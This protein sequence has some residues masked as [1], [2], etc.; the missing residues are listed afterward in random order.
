MEE[1][2]QTNPETSKIWFLDFIRGRIG[3]EFMMEEVTTLS[4]LCWLCDDPSLLENKRKYA[5]TTLR[6][7]FAITQFYID[8]LL[9][10]IA[11]NRYHF[12]DAGLKRCKE[13]MVACGLDGANDFVS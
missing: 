3:H 2:E 13:V 5:E 9:E 12:T 6:A 8:G 1:Y 11:P 4:A 10:Q 7:Y